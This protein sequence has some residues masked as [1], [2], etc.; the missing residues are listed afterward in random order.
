MLLGSPLLALGVPDPFDKYIFCESDPSLMGVLQRR[1]KRLFPKANVHF[2]TVD[3]N[4]QID[5]ICRAIPPHSKD[6]RVLSVVHP[7]KTGQPT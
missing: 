4:E 3:C 1:V 7:A 6:R 5:E 2:A